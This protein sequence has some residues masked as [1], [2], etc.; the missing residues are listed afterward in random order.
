VAPVKQTAALELKEPPSRSP[1][2][3]VVQAAASQQTEQPQDNSV[4]RA[5]VIRAVLQV[6]DNSLPLE[7]FSKRGG[8]V[9]APRLGV[10]VEQVEMERY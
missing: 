1:F 8:L 9:V 7:D 4:V 3:V 2:T 10:L 5:R 6:I